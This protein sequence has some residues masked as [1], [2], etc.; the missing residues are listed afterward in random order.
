MD[1]QAIEQTAIHA[2]QD[3]VNLTKHLSSFLDSNDKTPSWDGFIYIYKNEKKSK[4]NL[5]G[6]LPA[7]IK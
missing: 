1:N 7:Q 6:R 3:R 4:D 5:T 2:V